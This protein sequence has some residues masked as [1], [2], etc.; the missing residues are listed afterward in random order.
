MLR[1]WMYLTL[2]PALTTM[3]ACPAAAQQRSRGGMRP[4]NVAPARLLVVEAVQSEL[5][6][7][8]DQK[9]KAAEINE[10]LSKSRRELFQKIAKD[11]HERSEKVAELDKKT[12]ASIE[13][14]LDAQQEKRLKE[15]LLQVNGASE[16]L[17]SNMAEALQITKE[18]HKKLTEA[19]RANA[20]AKKDA[21]ENFDGDRQAKTLELQRE[22]DKKLLSVLTEEQKKK[23]EEMQGKKVSIKLFGSESN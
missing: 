6:L 23:F 21:L 11:S 7:T 4:G 8:D 2:A 1:T 14:L 22:G 5:K 10:T 17:K 12:D 19:N 18:Q 20:K 15:L 16:L 13:E 3:L 9:A